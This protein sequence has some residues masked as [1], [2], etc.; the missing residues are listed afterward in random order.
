MKVFTFT[1]VTLIF[2]RIFSMMSH[3]TNELTFQGFHFLCTTL[4]DPSVKRRV[5]FILSTDKINYNLTVR[6]RVNRNFNSFKSHFLYDY[7][8]KMYVL[9][10]AICAIFIHCGILQTKRWKSHLV[11]TMCLTRDPCSKD[12]RRFFPFL[13]AISF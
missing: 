3:Y 10:F 9:Y 1:H 13:S 11:N 2:I 4:L 5:S 6:R 12:N 7:T 8:K